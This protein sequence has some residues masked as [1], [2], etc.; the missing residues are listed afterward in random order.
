MRVDI[1][2]LFPEMFAGPLGYSMIGRAIE[3]TLLQV[4]LTNIR[5]FATD[6][7]RTVDDYPYGGGPGMVMKPG[8]IFDAVEAVVTP[9]SPIILLSPRGRLFSQRIAEELAQREHLVLVCGHYEGVDERVREHLATDELSI[10]DY[11]LTGGELAAMVVVDAVGRLLPG[12]L[13]GEQSTAEESHSS[14]VLEYP[15]YTRPPEFRGWPVPEI[16]LSGNHGEIAR[17]RRQQA[18][19][20]TA[21]ARPDLLTDELRQELERI[22]ISLPGHDPAES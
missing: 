21:E 3:R 4:T 1:M 7:H 22:G 19:R 20:H 15:H 16:L 18:L 8:P 12:V 11:V 9:E 10:G 2:T 14:G 17:W 6:R 13:G 5:D